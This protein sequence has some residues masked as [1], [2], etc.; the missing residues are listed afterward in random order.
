MKQIKYLVLTVLQGAEI[1]FCYSSSMA[2]GEGHLLGVW[3]QQDFRSLYS[4][5]S[6]QSGDMYT[7][8]MKT[9]GVNHPENGKEN[10]SHGV[11]PISNGSESFGS[12]FCD[13][14][15]VSAGLFK[16]AVIAYSARVGSRAVCHCKLDVLQL[17]LAIQSQAT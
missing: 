16:F 8:A 14:W 9:A 2:L 11:V 1:A 13:Y 12:N 17:F 15:E 4:C 5:G 3:R 6:L 10:R 7:P